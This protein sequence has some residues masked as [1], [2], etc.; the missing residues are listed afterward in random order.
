M[1]ATVCQRVV[2]I[3][4]YAEGILMSSLIFPLRFFLAGIA[5]MTLSVVCTDS[6]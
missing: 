6:Y 3:Y 5:D 1:V 2:E 4:S